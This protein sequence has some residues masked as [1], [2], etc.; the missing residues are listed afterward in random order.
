VKRT[1]DDLPQFHVQRFIKRG[2][3][4]GTWEGHA[5]RVHGHGLRRLTIGDRQ[6]DLILAPRKNVPGT[7]RF[8]LDSTGEKVTYLLVTPSGEIGSRH[9]ISDDLLYHS[10]RISKK[11]RRAWRRAKVRIKLGESVTEAWC[12][13]HPEIPDKPAGMYWSR[14][15]R[16]RRRLT[17]QSL[18]A[19]GE[20]NPFEVG[21][22]PG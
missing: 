21:T 10:Q 9:E 18:E 19:S 3:T 11:R 6:Y 5:W 16:L 22:N 2:I 4:S 13:E 12:L 20:H 14:Y 7:Q 17:R 8:I 1:I 15:R